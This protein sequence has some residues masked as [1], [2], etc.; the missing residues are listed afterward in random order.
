MSEIDAHHHFWRVGRGDYG[1]MDNNPAVDDIRRDFLPGDLD[2][3][4]QACGVSKTVLVQAAPTV[5]ETDFLLELASRAPHVA[6]VVGWIDF[7]DKS[8]EVE[9]DRLAMHSAFSGVRPMIQDIADPEWMHSAKVQWAYSALIERDLTFDALGKPP[10]LAPFE[11]LFQKYPDLRVVI[12]HGMKPV[13]T[14]RE[15]DQWAAGMTRI[16]QSTGAFCKVS[17]LLTEAA[18]GDGLDVIKPYVEHLL[19]VYG[20]SRLMWGSDWP[21]LNLASDYVSWHA[22]VKRLIPEQDHAAVFADT[23]TRFYR[24]D[25]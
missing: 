10:H 11:R 22:M 9:L 23:A 20:A 16:A 5:S 17:G 4:R 25:R 6:K 2:S 1:W 14:E 7:E 13:I 18:K 24:L 21:V 19:S 8:S 12:D 3:A 15:F